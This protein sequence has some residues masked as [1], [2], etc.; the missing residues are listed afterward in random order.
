MQAEHHL[1]PS[2]LAAG[3]A[4]AGTELQLAGDAEGDAEGASPHHGCGCSNGDDNED[5]VQVLHVYDGQGF[6][7]PLDNDPYGEDGKG[8]LAE[9]EAGAFDAWG[10][11]AAAEVEGG[12]GGLDGADTFAQPVGPAS[13]SHCGAVGSSIMSCW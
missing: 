12:S 7:D 5:D 10:D 4:N 2:S 1:A 3:A 6:A 8:D 13:T 11:A 9:A